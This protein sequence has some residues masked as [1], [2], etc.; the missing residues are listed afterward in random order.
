M[1]LDEEAMWMPVLAVKRL[2]EGAKLP[3]RAHADDAGADLYAHL[4]A[5]LVVWPGKARKVPTGVAV[6]IPPGYVGL[7]TTRSSAR[8]NGWDVHGVVDSGYTGEI[9][10]LVR[11]DC[12]HPQELA[13]FA[14]IAQLLVMPAPALPI[15]EV[16]ELGQTERGEAGFGSS[17]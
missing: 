8:L 7:I 14:R 15:V 1:T 12:E 2:R 11:N 9:H 16:D 3:T 5:P 10:L 13:P 17:G 4:D 6:A